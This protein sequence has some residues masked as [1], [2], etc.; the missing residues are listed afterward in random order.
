MQ[1][2]LLNVC[3]NVMDNALMAARISYCLAFIKRFFLK[4][5]AAHQQLVDVVRST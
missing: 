4:T 1:T 5:R 3:R 2:L